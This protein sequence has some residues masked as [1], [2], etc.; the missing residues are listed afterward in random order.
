MAAEIFEF[1]DFFVSESDPGTEETLMMEDNSG[2]K[3]EVTLTLKRNI[4]LGD[5]QAARAAG[6]VT[7]INPQNGQQVVDAFDDAL[8]VIHLLSRVIKKWPF[9]R[10][11][12]MVPVTV[13]YVTA[14]NAKN[15]EV[16]NI[17][18]QRLTSGQSEETQTDF[19][20]PSDVA[21]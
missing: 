13:K 19:V 12:E 15:A 9:T 20:K 16:F 21:F 18:A 10:D 8:F 11:G 17:L 6:T 14:L 4:S 5:I 1:A 3:R 7:H 2:K